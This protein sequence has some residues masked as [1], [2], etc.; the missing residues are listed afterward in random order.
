MRLGAGTNP[1]QET[2]MRF[3][4]FTHY[5]IEKSGFHPLSVILDIDS[6]HAIYTEGGNTVVA[7]PSG[8]ITLNISERDLHRMM[9]DSR[10]EIWSVD[11]VEHMAGPGR[12]GL[13]QPAAP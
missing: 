5:R 10:P 12:P 3:R 2:T 8:C 9:T 1:A 11:A 7:T 13:E 4:L 6:I